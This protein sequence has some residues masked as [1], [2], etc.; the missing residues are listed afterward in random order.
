MGLV[1]KQN[2]QLEKLKDEKIYYLEKIIELQ[3]KLIEKLNEELNVVKYTVSS[4]L[5]SL[6]PVLRECRSAA[7]EPLKSHLQ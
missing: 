1:A 6:S 7:L 3:N 4:E 2:G 5:N